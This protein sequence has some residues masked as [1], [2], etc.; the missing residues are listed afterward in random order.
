M[1]DSLCDCLRHIKTEPGT[2]FENDKFLGKY[3]RA[4]M[5]KEKR[6]Q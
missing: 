3:A 5:V 2:M 1:S 4:K 6:G